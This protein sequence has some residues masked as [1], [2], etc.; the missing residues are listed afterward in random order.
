[1][2]QQGGQGGGGA[3]PPPPPAPLLMSPF[4]GALDL[5]SSEGTRLFIQATKGL[6]EKHLY[7]GK[8]ASLGN[9]LDKVQ[10]R[11]MTCHWEVIF[12]ITLQDGAPE[13]A[14]LLG[15]H[16]RVSLDRVKV[17]R[18]ARNQG[19]VTRERQCARMAYVFLMNSITDRA[20]SVASSRYTEINEDGPTLLK[21]L[22]S[23]TALGTRM[24]AFQIKHK[25]GKLS[26]KSYSYKVDEM[27]DDVRC[28]VKLLHAANETHQDLPLNLFNAYAPAPSED[29]QF[30]VRTLRNEYNRDSTITA[31]QIMTRIQPVYDD[32]KSQGK[33]VTKDP[34]DAQIVALKAQVQKLENTM[35]TRLST[36]GNT[37][38]TKGQTQSKPKVDDKG[39][40]AKRSPPPQWKFKN[41]ND[42]KEMSKD[43]ITYYW[44]LYHSNPSD[45]RKKGMWVRHS[46][47]E[48]C[49][50]K[51]KAEARKSGSGLQANIAQ[52]DNDADSLLGDQE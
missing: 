20:L 46:P 14:N 16:G 49:K 4:E 37:S 38:S 40:N 52:L 3:P 21:V 1:M 39:K 17:V 33:W 27:H 36:D 29:F 12:H 10:V 19:P 11:V 41:P 7:D 42:D 2:A 34:K 23:E 22:L 26:L 28:D 30:E 35:G 44:C 8:P 31:E 6:E 50:A 9:F 24:S 18:D 45:R 43:G 48:V 32:L 13:T 47:S 5:A 25:L 51:E 15:D